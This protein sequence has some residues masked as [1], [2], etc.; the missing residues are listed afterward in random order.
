MTNS[1]AYISDVH[2]LEEL[3]N[4]IVS[5]SES[6]SNIDANVGS[7]INGVKESLCR[8]LDFIQTKLTEAE[9]AL[10]DAETNLN[11]CQS[12]QA[13]ASA[14]GTVGP[15]CAMEECA[16]QTA[17]AEVE[18]WRMRYE[19]GQQIVGE[20]EREI[21]E[22]NGPAGGHALIRTLCEQQTPDASRYLNVCIERLNDILATDMGS[23]VGMIDGGIEKRQIHPTAD[24]NHSD[25]S[26]ITF[27][28]TVA[29]AN[30]DSK[31]LECCPNC[32][33]PL[34][35]CTCMNDHV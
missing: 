10:S 34:L 32:G 26:R 14:M 12:A 23:N 7:Y 3:N 11:M 16:V 31:Q 25:T 27:G 15:S 6:M 8:Q 20:C 18:K 33:R 2:L 30:G 29:D 28:P 22:Y 24:N 5:S 4:V 17:R 13:L 1:G 21:A 19:Q 9:N 35:L